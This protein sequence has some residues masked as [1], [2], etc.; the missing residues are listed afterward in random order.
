MED[1]TEWWKKA[2]GKPTRTKLLNTCIV[3]APFK[4]IETCKESQTRSSSIDLQLVSKELQ[5][6]WGGG[7]P[8]IC[9]G[10]T[11]LETP[12]PAGLLKLSNLGH[13]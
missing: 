9:F 4:K 5:Y 12:V 2:N 7:N 13:S 8:L 10:N 6:K 11:K 1:E 3:R